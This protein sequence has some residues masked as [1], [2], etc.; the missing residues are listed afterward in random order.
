M[1]VVHA[2]RLTWGATNVSPS[3]VPGPKT[4]KEYGPL[5]PSAAMRTRLPAKYDP[6]GTCRRN[7]PAGCDTRCGAAPSKI[8]RAKALT[9]VS[10][11]AFESGEDVGTGSNE[12]LRRSRGIERETCNFVV[13]ERSTNDLAVGIDGICAPGFHIK[14]DEVH[15]QL[16]R[17]RTRERTLPWVVRPRRPDRQ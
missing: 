16:D 6:A 8:R 7:V 15:P 9:R 5:T 10:M 4:T 13:P 12:R 3:I 2:P 11:C 17:A 1:I 14:D